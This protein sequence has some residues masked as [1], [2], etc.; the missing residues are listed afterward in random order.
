MQKATGE[1]DYEF[2]QLVDA[3]LPHPLIDPQLGVAPSAAPAHLQ[4]IVAT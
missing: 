2:K 3:D 4:A 1:A